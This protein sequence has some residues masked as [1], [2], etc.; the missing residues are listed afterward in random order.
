MRLRSPIES[1]IEVPF[2][3]A[4]TISFGLAEAFETF[5]HY[6]SEQ[7]ARFALTTFPLFN[8]IVKTTLVTILYESQVTTH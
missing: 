4:K 2:G 6:F 3:L 7:L 1:P 5:V 8:W